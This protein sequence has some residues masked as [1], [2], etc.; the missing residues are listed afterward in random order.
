MKKLS[1]ILVCLI[2]VGFAYKADAASCT[3]TTSPYIK[4][5][6]PNGGELFTPGQQIKVKWESC[7]VKGKVFIGFEWPSSFNTNFGITASSVNNTGSSFYNAPISS[8]FYSPN[9][10]QYGKYYKISIKDVDTGKIFD[11]SDNDFTVNQCNT[12]TAGS[13]S[14]S[15]KNTPEGAIFGSGHSTMNDFHFATITLKTD[16]KSGPVC[17]N[18]VQLGSLTDPKLKINKTYIYDKNNNLLATV[19]ISDWDTNGGAWYAW[20]PIKMDIKK[21]N[22]AVDFI[23]KAD[24]LD[25]KSLTD[26]LFNLGISGMNFDYPGARGIGLSFGNV[27]AVN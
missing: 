25:S 15:N 12:L 13:Y 19:P 3:K 23:I 4:I 1:M 8:N 5:L 18:N 20:A 27:F 14:M 7:N 21:G 9:G 6:S 26:G 17:I 16:K 22:T 2:I 11:S 10:L 24:V